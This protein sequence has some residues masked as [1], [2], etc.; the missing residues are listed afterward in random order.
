MS[1]TGRPI[2]NCLNGISKLLLEELWSRCGPAHRDSRAGMR[3]GKRNSTCSAVGAKVRRIN[4]SRQGS[5][6]RFALPTRE[7]TGKERRILVYAHHPACVARGT[8]DRTIRSSST[9]AKIFPRFIACLPSRSGRYPIGDS[10][11]R[12]LISP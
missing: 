7:S 3:G 8:E 4:I 12:S 1:E 10:V 6:R 2:K 11:L 9:I 5:H